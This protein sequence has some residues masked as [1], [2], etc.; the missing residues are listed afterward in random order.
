MILFSNFL[1][2]E[3]CCYGLLSSSNLSVIVLHLSY[4]HI[5]TKQFNIISNYFR[6]AFLASLKV[7][8]RNDFFDFSSLDLRSALFLPVS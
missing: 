6:S 7:G 5:F 1:N 2:P 8:P 4:Y 3:E